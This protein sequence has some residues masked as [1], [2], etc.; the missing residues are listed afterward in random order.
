MVDVCGHAG[1][2]GPVLGPEGAQTGPLGL[3]CHMS[4]QLQRGSVPT[5]GKAQRL[6][7]LRV[8]LEIQGMCVR[9]GVGFIGFLTF[10]FADDVR[11]IAEAQ[12]RFHSL[13]SGAMAGRYR[14]W[15]CVVQ[16]HKDNRIHFHLVIAMREDIRRGFNFA[17]VKARDYSS[18]SAYLKAEWA[19]LRSVMPEYSFGRHELLPVRIADGFGRYVARYVGRTENTR[20]DEKGARLVRFSKGFTR[21]VCGPFSKCD[22]IETRA[23]ERL[24]FIREW[25]GFR[26]RDHMEIEIGPRWKY[27]LARLMYCS[28]PTFFHVMTQV[29][30]SLRLYGGPMFVVADEF[31][32]WDAGEED[33]CDG[34]PPLLDTESPQQVRL[35][36]LAGG[37]WGGASPS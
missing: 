8:E 1:R 35:R 30:A 34:S 25:L 21:C 4:E 31:A 9:H 6:A 24:P 7:R 17:Q 18:A 19:F 37:G 33:V 32:R 13:F 10:T 2:G 11:T 15:V 26:D 36:A 14:E 23:R 27:H 29:R 5:G 3:P 20:Q 28:T 16:R 22:V 12:K